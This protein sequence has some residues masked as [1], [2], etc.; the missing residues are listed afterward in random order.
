MLRAL[1]FVVKVSILVAG[2]VWLALRPGTVVVDWMDYKVTVQAGFFFIVLAFALFVAFFLLRLA[3]AFLSVG[4]WALRFR[5]TRLRDKGERALVRG[6]SA[7]A[8]GD[9]RQASKQARRARD[10]LPGD[11][12]MVL[13]LEAQAA[14]MN[15]DWVG[16][17]AAY[18][19]LAGGAETGFIG[20]R[21]LL[22]LALESG[23]PVE[24][25]AIARKAL[26][27]RPG[28]G[29]LLKLVYD[30]ETQAQ[31]W[32][33]AEKT[34]RKCVKAGA[35]DPVRARSDRVAMKLAQADADQAAGREDAAWKAVREAF[36]LDS[37][38]VPA[39]V[40]YVRMAAAR[41]WRWRPARALERAWKADPHPD[42]A[43]LW[44]IIAPA[45]TMGDP[46]A[47]M[48]WFARL[49]DLRPD[50]PEGHLALARV[51]LDEKLWGEARYSMDQVEKLRPSARL[52]RLA[53][54]LDARSGY[55]A[56]GGRNWSDLAA[57]APPEKIW[58][59]SRTGRV[60]DRWS[61]VARPHGSFNTIV[62]SEPGV[63]APQTI[64]MTGLLT[65]ATGF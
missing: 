35:I 42:L 24:S 17:R 50:H 8:A 46:A 20:V 48:K 5:R 51:A 21:G 18:E 39:V 7:V 19:A 34:L 32:P 3:L 36:T 12:G 30:L 43:D 55:K 53:A 31:D 65:S 49:V 27:L 63:F 9:A 37:L 1:W 60:Y 29:W 14:R 40:R 6:L 2:A 59:C 56:A 4:D 23:Q 47:R 22:N 54:D 38:F 28:Q 13:M 58:I 64:G 33:A 45:K 61:A 62:W 44:P 25:L 10:C 16:A 11:K 52:Y 26:A 15:R 57:E 41:G